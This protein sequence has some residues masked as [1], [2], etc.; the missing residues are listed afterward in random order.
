MVS[1]AKDQADDETKVKDV[2]LHLLQNTQHSFSSTVHSTDAFSC[3]TEEFP[4][5]QLKEAAQEMKM[6]I[7]KHSLNIY[8]YRYLF[9]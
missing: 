9:F 7:Q 2:H 8:F 6:I 4:E 1:D 3:A 5:T